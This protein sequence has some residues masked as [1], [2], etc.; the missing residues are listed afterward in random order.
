MDIL[1]ILA[2]MGKLLLDPVTILYI[3]LGGQAG[4]VFGMMPGLTTTTA[5][6]LL[7]GLTFSLS[8]DKAIAVILAAY[9]GSVTGGSR[10]AILVNIPGTPAQAAVCLD[11][12]PLA[13]QGKAAQAI[14]LSVTSST[15][16]TL[17][18]FICLALFTPLIGTAALS[19]GTYEFF[20]LAVFGVVIAGSL[21][22]PKDPIKGW[23]AGFLGLVL[24]T[25]GDDSIHAV[26]R[27]T[28]NLTAFSGGFAL[29]PVLIGAYGIP[30]V[31]D[32][33]RKK[34]TI[35]VQAKVGRVVPRFLEVMQYKWVILRSSLIGIIIG[36]IPGVGSD[37]AS[38]LSYFTAKKASKTPEMFGKGSIEGFV[39]AEAGD[40]SCIGGDIIP[41]LTLAIPGSAPAAV[42]LAAMTIHNLRPGPLLVAEQPEVVGQ[43]IAISMV[44]TFAVFILSLAWTRQMV[45]ILMIPRYVLMPA[46]FIICVTG[47]YALS[48]RLFDIYVM[49]AFGL[50]GVLLNEL[51][52]PVAPLVL[53]FI[54]GP[55]AEDNLRRGLMITAGDPLPFFTRPIS[56]VLCAMLVVSVLWSTSRGQRCI[57]WVKGLWRGKRELELNEER[58]Q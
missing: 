10:S 17:L 4:I 22:S 25:V 49:Y 9:V 57:A 21:C 37:T 16:G 42:L 33:L 5:L 36:I 52:Y 24:M 1:S 23:I 28:F 34:R 39:A 56:A 8:P 15:I 11:G 3:F 30:E 55:M 32:S 47:A 7:T 44:S 2:G 27:F 54:L 53:G 43:I 50:L 51:D 13:L 40:N 45:K 41:T 19:F 6:S 35:S 31:L 38:W 48:G 14:G 12:Y 46:V 58:K 29:I 18:G 20:W 26:D